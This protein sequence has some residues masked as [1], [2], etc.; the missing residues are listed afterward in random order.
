V[1]DAG[2]IGADW[3]RKKTIKRTRIPTI[4]RINFFMASPSSIFCGLDL[5]FPAG[6]FFSPVEKVS[7]FWNPRK[8]K[9]G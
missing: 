2:S 4:P 8:R 6:R 7:Y 1:Y 9:G 3:N 5:A